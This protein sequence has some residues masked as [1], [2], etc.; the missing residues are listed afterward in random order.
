MTAP[1]A[2]KPKISTGWSEMEAE[3]CRLSREGL[4]V[5]EISKRVGWG[6]I[7]VARALERNNMPINNPSRQKRGRMKPSTFALWSDE[8][9]AVIDVAP[10]SKAAIEMFA[11]EFPESHRTEGAIDTRWRMRHKGD[12]TMAPGSA[13]KAEAV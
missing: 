9:L 10:T 6:R 3:M 13:S 12:R 4:T 5:L 11:I 2:T 8:E 1:D 7:A